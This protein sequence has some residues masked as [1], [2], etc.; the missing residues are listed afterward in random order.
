MPSRSDAT[1]TLVQKQVGHTRVQLA[2]ARH[3]SA[4]SA[5]RGWSSAPRSRSGRPSVATGSPMR[6]A[7]GRD[8][9]DRGG[10]VVVGGR[11]QVQ[12]L[13]DRGPGRAAGPD[14][15]PIVEFGEDEVGAVADFRPGAHR[16]AEAGAG[17]A[18]ALD[19][20]HQGGV[21]AGRVIGIAERAGPHRAVLDPEGRELACPDAEEGDRR[22]RFHD[23]HDGHRSTLARRPCERHE[24][25]MREALP[26]GQ[27][28]AVVERPL[29]PAIR[30]AVLARRRFAPPAHRELGGAPDL[31][32]DDR[33]V[34]DRGAKHPTALA[35]ERI[36]QAVQVRADQEPRPGHHHGSI[37]GP[38][39]SRSWTRVASRRRMTQASR[40]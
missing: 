17:G 38:Y 8:L 5:Q 23:R 28:D 26:G 2:H 7:D 18:G 24:G 6:R 31:V 36:E 9:G 14:R 10:L 12:A 11:G 32:V 3:R 13:E 21:A 35:A 27:R 40:R 34:D 33:A 20:H 1:L 22:R 30:Q 29:A 37:P 4:T 16:G 25:W 15:E 19:G 39:R